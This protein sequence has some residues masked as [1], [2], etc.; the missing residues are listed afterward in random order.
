MGE[1]SFTARLPSAIFS[2]ASCV[3]VFFLARRLG[4]RWPLLATGLFAAFPLQVR[5]ALEARAY[6]LALCLSIWSTVLFFLWIDHSKRFRFALFYGLCVVAGLY[7][8][9]YT[10][11]VPLAHVMWLCIAAPGQQGRNSR[12]LISTGL[13]VLLAG[14][15]FLPWYLYGARM[16][17]AMYPH[18][19]INLRVILLILKELTGTGY[20][21]TAIVLSGIF[22]ALRSG[23]KH[24]GRERQFW[25][26]YLGVPILGVLVADIVFIYFVAIRQIIV[27][28]APLALLFAAGVESLNR[29]AGAILSAA[30][31]I[32]TLA[33]NVSFFR[34]PRENWRAAA[35]LL[36]AEKCVVYSPADSPRLYAFFIPQLAERVCTPANAKRV[37]LAI[38]PYNV[39][40]P[41]AEAQRQL[42]E[43]GFIRR[44]ELNPAT[45]RIEVYERP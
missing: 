30:L 37:A 24:R 5:Y 13:V 23:F 44:T 9:P 14:A 29:R 21:G 43:S 40:N 31:V 15:A 45:P 19:A 28:L 35:V 42:T 22:F 18:S 6:S 33:G 3:G 34:R 38:S 20:I 39:N 25:L 11:F 1:S 4:L 12:L 17:S 27:V 16:W 36:A 32:A 8:Q 7:T 41:F 2:V 10:L 26:L